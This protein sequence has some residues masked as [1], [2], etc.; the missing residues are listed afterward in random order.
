MSELFPARADIDLD[1]ITANLG[2]VRE[3]VDDQKLLGVVK[4]DAYGHGRAQCARALLGAGADYL[5]VAQVAEAVNL[6]EEVGPGPAIL[7]WIYAPGAALG[8][9]LSAGIELSVGAFWALDE[10]AAAARSTGI[11]AKIHLK[12]DTGMARGGFNL[13]DVAE[14]SRRIRELVAEGVCEL[15]GLWSHLARADEVLTGLRRFRGKLPAAER[16]SREDAH[17]R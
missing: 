16:L 3:A 12:V 17:E 5:G 4:A 7:A 8:E 6:R 15:Q 14:A 2:V 9:A 1:A 13:S 11:T 10:V